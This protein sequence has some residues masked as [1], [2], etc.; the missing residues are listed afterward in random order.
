MISPSDRLT[1]LQRLALERIRQEG[2]RAFNE[3]ILPGLEAKIIQLSR[4]E[5]SDGLNI[6]VVKKMLQD[7]LK[8]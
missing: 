5:K 3:E 8:I 7:F 1:V 4:K 2:A 6:L